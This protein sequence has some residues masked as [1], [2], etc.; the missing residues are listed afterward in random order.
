MKH[1]L[2]MLAAGVSSRMKKALATGSEDIDPKLL[3]EANTLPKC[4]L[5]V[6]VNGHRF[7]D[8]LVYNAYQAGFRDMIM[9]LHPNDMITESHV[10]D[11]IN[12]FCMHDLTLK[13]ARQYIA[14]GR[15]KP[16]GTGDAVDQAL[17][18]CE[19]ADDEFFTLTNSDNLCSV[20]AFRKAYACEKNTILP[21][22]PLSLGIAPEDR[23][24]YGLIASNPA[25]ETVALVEKPD[26][27]EIAQMESLGLRLSI[28]MNLVTMRVGDVVTLVH[29]LVPHP[30]RDEKE[31]TDVYTS[32]FQAN[33]LNC[34]VIEEPIPDLTSKADIPRV[35]SYLR[36]AY[37]NIQ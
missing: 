19:L 16:F 22:D 29:N 8:Y 12:G 10:R 9:I 27:T 13:I 25:G 30:V 14:E 24:R 18:Q 17:T 31:I 36:E 11:T 35:Q 15:E 33:N 34:V 6:G 21:Y 3:E 32:L 37:P 26:A 1:T 20:E 28:N 23:S 7:I 5:S 2:I 4:M